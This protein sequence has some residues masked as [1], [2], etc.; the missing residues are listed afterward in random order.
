[1]SNQKHVFAHPDA[2]MIYRGLQQLLAAIGNLTEIVSTLDQAVA[3]L[4]SDLT[5]AGDG[6]N[7]DC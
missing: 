3:D 4:R 5:E 7:P 6:D 2:E 1:M